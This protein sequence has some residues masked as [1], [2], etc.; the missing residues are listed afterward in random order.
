MFT[1]LISGASSPGSVWKPSE[2][3]TGAAGELGRGRVV[4]T[5]RQECLDHV[6]VVSERHLDA[7]LTEFLLYYN[8]IDANQSRMASS[9]HDRF[10][11]DFIT[12]TGGRHDRYT[13]AA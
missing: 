7:L 4:R 6:I 2:R 11:A 1:V 8:V 12:R 13:F 10:S 9:L 5:L 3:H